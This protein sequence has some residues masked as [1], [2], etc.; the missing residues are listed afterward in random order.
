MALS[1]GGDQ[2][3]VKDKL[4]FEFYGGRSKAT[5][6]RTKVKSRSWPMRW[7][8][9]SKQVTSWATMRWTHPGARRVRHRPQTW[10][11]AARHRYGRITPPI[12]CCAAWAG[13]AGVSG[14]FLSGDD[15][16]LR[17]AGDAAGSGGYQPPRQR[18]SACWMLP[19]A[20]IDHHRRAAN[21]ISNATMSFHEPY[22]SSACELMAELPVP[23]RA[24]DLLK[25]GGGHALGHHAR[26]KG[27]HRAPQGRRHLHLPQ[28]RR[29]FSARSTY[30]YW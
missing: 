20:V 3:V 29:Y 23:G 12:R 21:Y 11:S 5:E 28:G 14:A 25:G 16:F 26:H 27:L 1:R 24:G 2:A 7:R 19:A 18:S 17:P 8:S 30:R 10:R 15:A 4:N 22:A 6:K 13:P 9:S